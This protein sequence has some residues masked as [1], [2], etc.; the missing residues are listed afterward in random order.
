MGRKSYTQ[1]AVADIKQQIATLAQTPHAG[2]SLQIRDVVAEIFQ[3]VIA[4]RTAGYS[5]EEILEV[6]KPGGLT[7]SLSTFRR[8]LRSIKSRSRTRHNAHK[9]AALDNNT[10]TEIKPPV[11]PVVERSRTPK[12]Q[13]APAHAGYKEER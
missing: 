2:Q 11:V 12:V 3:E 8:H 10:K 13:K 7:L 9:A 5:L 1:S 6:A 4:A